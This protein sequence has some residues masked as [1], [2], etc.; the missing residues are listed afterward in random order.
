[1][2]VTRPREQAAALARLIEA[3]GARAILFPAL[4]IRDVGDARELRALIERLHEFDRAVFVSPTAVQK[5]LQLIGQWPEKV[6]VAALG[7][8]TARELHRHGIAGVLVPRSGAD[9]EALL[10]SPELQQV[11]GLHIVIFRGAGGRE[12]LGDT[13][14]AR[15]ARIEYANCYV[16]ASPRADSAALLAAWQRGE[17]DAVTVFSAEALDNLFALLGRDVL[18]RT[19]L[20]A[21]H[22][23]IAEAARRHGVREVHVAGPGD[24]ELVGRLM[25]YFQA[26]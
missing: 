11:A 14:A 15:G 3:Q 7:Q 20:F 24:E 16:R 2:L 4:E 1:M 8:G 13:L 23:R 21:A 9:S 26:R 22:E 25:A 10:A 5:A 19:P 12:L 6:A 17:I 18:V